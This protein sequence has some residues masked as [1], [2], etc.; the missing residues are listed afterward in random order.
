L[1]IEQAR[2][3]ADL[4]LRD[5]QPEALDELIDAAGGDAADIRLLHDG[6]QRLLAALPGL[7]KRR[8]VAALADLRDLQLDLPGPGVPPPGP[9]AVAMGRAILGPLT[10]ISA[11]ELGHLGLHQLASDRPHGLS[12]HVAVL[13]AQ[14]LPDD[15]L[16]RHPVPT[17]HCRP[18]FV[19][20]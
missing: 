4:G 12:D 8:E 7:Q 3:A 13:L 11:D 9:I 6:D 5:P 16:D 18:P 19:E 2:D 14:H 15:L 20:P 10:V 17:G 1:L